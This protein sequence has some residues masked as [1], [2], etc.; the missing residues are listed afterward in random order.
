MTNK[1][2]KIKK[3]KAMY[4]YCQICMKRSGSWYYDCHPS[5]LKTKRHGSG[6]PIN[7][8]ECRRWK[9]NRTTQWK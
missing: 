2:Y 3:M 4:N 1:E 9:H 8:R 5:N 7:E 6:K